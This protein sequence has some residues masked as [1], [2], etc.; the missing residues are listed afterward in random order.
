MG[1]SSSP[2]G[3]TGTHRN[4]KARLQGEETF[5]WSM[6]YYWP[7]QLLSR[8]RVTENAL[9][10]ATVRPRGSQKKLRFPCQDRVLSGGVMMEAEAGVSVEGELCRNSHRE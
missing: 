6:G 5:G 1:Q 8:K 7:P 10:G 4:P 3:L 2:Q 9:A